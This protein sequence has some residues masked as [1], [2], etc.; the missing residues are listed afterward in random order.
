MSSVRSSLELGATVA[1]ALVALVVGGA[2][3]WDRAPARD[4][5]VTE[6]VRVVEDWEEANLHGI[7]RGSPNADFVL[8]ELIDFQCP[9]CARLVPRIDSLLEDF[10]TEVAVVFQH[11]PLP[12]HVHAMPAA[13]AAE[14]ADRQGA[15]WS[16]Y[17]ALLAGQEDFGREPWE[18]FAVEAG[19]ADLGAFSGCMEL[20]AD[21]FPRIGQGIALAAR[22]GA[23]GTPTVWV[24][25]RTVEPDLESVREAITASR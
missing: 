5:A 1:V 10:P 12:N 23:R 21:S 15:F 24:N 2:Y 6:A 22:T 25:G 11:F 13:T 17:R 9:F 18:G 7:R 3:M 20:P 14:C 4:R 8:T 19:V 16:M